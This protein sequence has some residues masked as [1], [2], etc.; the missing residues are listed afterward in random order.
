MWSNNVNVLNESSQYHPISHLAMKEIN[1]YF[2]V[3]NK[4]QKKTKY[5]GIIPT[6]S[7]I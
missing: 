5:S 3:D 4:E 1:V 6:T 2:R 7:W